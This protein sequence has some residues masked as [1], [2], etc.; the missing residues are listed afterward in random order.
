MLDKAL[1]EAIP[2]LKKAY[3]S[4]GPGP[5]LAGIQATPEIGLSD[6]LGLPTAGA[7][8]EVQRVQLV[9]GRYLYRR[10]PA[11]LQQK[12]EQVGLQAWM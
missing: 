8:L 3:I 5:I 7:G 4:L 11:I 1:P 2:I 12:G 10:I 6:D 9:P